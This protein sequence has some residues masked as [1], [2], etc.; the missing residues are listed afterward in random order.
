MVRPKSVAVWTLCCGVLCSPLSSAELATVGA[1]LEG[2]PT[3]ADRPVLV[4]STVTIGRIL[5]EAQFG[6]RPASVLDSK[7]GSI[8]H[9][10]QK[11]E[12]RALIGLPLE[13]AGADSLRRS[14]DL[15]VVLLPLLAGVAAFTLRASR[16]I[17]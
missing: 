10:V 5:N 6:S 17:V 8:I 16:K 15:V 4:A 7:T 13:L 12:K 14:P 3:N 9:A 1:S 2:P 11:E